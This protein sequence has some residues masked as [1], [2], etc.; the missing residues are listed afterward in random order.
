AV[1]FLVAIAD[2]EGPVAI[3]P[4]RLRDSI[5]NAV[6]LQARR[7]L[8]IRAQLVAAAVQPAPL[9]ADLAARPGIGA[10]IDAR[11]VNR[12]LGPHQRH[13]YRYDAILRV[14]EIRR[15]GNCGEVI[16]IDQRLLQLE[17]LVDRIELARPPRRVALQKLVGK[18][19]V[20]VVHRAEA[21]P[22]ARIPFEID[23][24]AVRRAHHFDAML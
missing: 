6:V 23:L 24:R 8:H 17:Q 20:A 3:E 15:D 12:T 18:L 2:A 11:R 7:V 22:F 4:A 9:E 19:Y 13:V 14:L 16:R 5:L 1:G 10:D 21:M